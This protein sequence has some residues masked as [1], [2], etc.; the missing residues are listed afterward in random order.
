MDI[1][2]TNRN[3][4]ALEAGIHRFLGSPLWQSYC[5]LNV[6]RQHRGIKT[7]ESLPLALNMVQFLELSARKA[8][9]RFL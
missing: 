5:V 9:E 4:L 1:R 8:T 2:R 6:T 3:P 7:E